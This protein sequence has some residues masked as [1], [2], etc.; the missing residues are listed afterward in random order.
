MKSSARRNLFSAVVV[1]VLAGLT[2][3][4]SPGSLPWEYAR[5]PVPTRIELVITDQPVYPTTFEFP[6]VNTPEYC[7]VTGAICLC[8][9]EW[10]HTAIAPKPSPRASLALLR[11]M[12]RYSCSSSDDPPLCV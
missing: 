12:R 5:D 11:Q 6:V 3:F 7:C 10:Y 2:R 4:D 8:H 1:C 9:T